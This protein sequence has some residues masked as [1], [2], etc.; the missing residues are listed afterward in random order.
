VT[1]W[2][3][4]AA[5]VLDGIGAPIDAVNVDTL[6]AWSNAET[7]PY[8][9]MRWNNPLNTT[10]PW[11]RAR[12]SGAQPGPHDVKIYATL[13]D[14][15]DATVTTL[16]AEP[17]YPAIVAN[18]RASLPR[19]QWGA[20]S[21]AGAQLH[22][23]GTGTNWLQATFGPAP[24]NIIPE[25]SFMKVISDDT[26][27]KWITNGVTKRD[28]LDGTELQQ[29]LALTGQAEALVLGRGY[30][31]RIPYA[32]DSTQTAAIL[33]AVWGAY[34]AAGAGLTALQAQALMDIHDAVIRMET[35]FKAA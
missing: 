1:D 24:G 35:A 4:W 23:W 6:W 14:G 20:Y 10:E 9:L 30:I 27:A 26:P 19:Q 22:M 32:A 25:E 34:S 2:E 16:I 17:Y 11:P 29:M 28:I 13:Q 31:D 7:A 33:A 15:I 18:L 8:N 21:A 5:G 12:D 3:A